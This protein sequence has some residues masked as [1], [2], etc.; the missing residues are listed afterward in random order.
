MIN[1]ERP[2]HEVAR[3]VITQETISR[4]S[5]AELATFANKAPLGFTPVFYG[6]GRFAF[7]ADW[8]IGEMSPSQRAELTIV[9]RS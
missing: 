9:L 5:D 1:P 3:K 7:V 8:A 4:M 2:L 6:N